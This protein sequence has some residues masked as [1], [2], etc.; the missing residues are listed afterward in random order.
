M[1]RCKDCKLEYEKKPDYCECGNDSFEEILPETKKSFL[2]Q[3]PQ[4][5]N[6]AKSFDVLST[7]IFGLCIILSILAWVFIGKESPDTKKT[8]KVQ[9]HATEQ[10]KND[11]KL[12]DINSFWDNTPPE[13]QKPVQEALQAPEVEAI[14]A[15]IQ[16]EMQLRALREEQER[17]MEHAQIQQRPQIPQDIAPQTKRPK[18]S[19]IKKR[20]TA[21]NS[22]MISYKSDLRQVLF[23]HLSVTSVQGE[24]RCEI[25]FSVDKS[26]RLLNRKFSKLSDNK[27]LNDAVY[28]MLMSVPRYS[29]PP[30]GYNGEKIKLSFYFDNGYYEVS[31]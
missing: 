1:F 28:N 19:P 24:G 10:I 20:E 21:S 5:Q 7:S 15:E 30:S 25:E 8:K 16:R 14:P 13:V 11:K 17:R 4:I 23:S 2:E 27:S 26:G 29:A 3:Y 31:Y 12:P 6:F 18:T 9:K 22:D